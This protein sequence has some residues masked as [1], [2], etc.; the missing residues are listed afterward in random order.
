MSWQIWSLE[1]DML[2][3]KCRLLYKWPSHKGKSL[4]V[5]SIFLK[6]MKCIIYL[7][8]SFCCMGSLRSRF[9]HFCHNGC[10]RCTTHSHFCGLC[11]EKK[12]CTDSF[13]QSLFGVFLFDR[14]DRKMHQRGFFPKFSLSYFFYLNSLYC[15]KAHLPFLLFLSHHCCEDL[16]SQSLPGLSFPQCICIRRAPPY[17]FTHIAILYVLLGCCSLCTCLSGRTRALSESFHDL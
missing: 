1:K 16:L 12:G 7:R 11:T 3:R 2:N 4:W 17:I 5:Q 6:L 13:C 15:F 10:K 9:W 14:N 8:K